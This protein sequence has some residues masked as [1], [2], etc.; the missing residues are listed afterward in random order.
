[1]V[2]K[3]YIINLIIL[4]S[5][6]VLGFFSLMGIHL[7]FENIQNKFDE[8]I[9]NEEIRYRIGERI[10]RHINAVETHY[11]KM[12]TLGEQIGIERIRKDILN[13]T[14]IIRQ[15]LDVLEKG[16]TAELKTELNLAESH[17]ETEMITYRKMSYERLTIE[18]IDLA[19]KLTA[20]EH[21]VDELAQFILQRQLHENS[22]QAEQEIIIFL[23]QLP[24]HFIR[25]KENA[26]RLLYESRK[27]MHLVEIQS[28]KE[29]A[30]Y[31][32]LQYLVAF[33]VIG[34]IVILGTLVARG[35][36]RTNKELVQSNQ[37]AKELA[38]KAQTADR[39]KSQFLA[40]MSHEIR[41]PLNG[42]IG[43]SHILT[44][45]AITAQNREYA[46]IIYENSHGLLDIIN[47]ILDISKI[48]Q[49]N[50]DI[51][52]EPFS[53]T[54]VLEKVVELFAIKAKE[55]S[56][57]F[58]FYASPTI[59]E[60]VIGDAVRLRQVLSN[61]LGNAI[62][63]T[64]QNGRVRFEVRQ[65]EID[66]HYVLLRFAIEDSGVGIPKQQQKKIFEPFVQADDGI[67]RKFGGTG[68]GLSISSD[69]IKKMGSS[70]GLESEVGVGSK[71]YFDMR[72][73]IGACFIPSEK[74]ES[75]HIFAILGQPTEFPEHLEV[76]QVYL[77]KWGKLQAWNPK[78]RVDALFCYIM[79]PDI[80]EKIVL[81]K[82]AFPHVLIIALRD[83][84]IGTLP[85]SLEPIV[86][87][88]LEC[89][90]YGSKIFNA[91]VS[92]FKDK[93]SE[94]IP[95]T[96]II[97]IGGKILVAE[98]N[99]TNRQLMQIYLEKLGVSFTMV[100]NGEE[101][102][103]LYCKENFDLVLMDINMPV[104]DGIAA[105]KA[106][107]ENEQT[108][109]RNHTPIIALTA[110]TLKGDKERYVTMGM[111]G[112]LS[113]PIVFEDLRN[114]L[115][116]YITTELMDKDEPLGLQTELK[117]NID[118]VA[119]A[120]KMGLDIV[121]LEMIL[122]NF[123]LTLEDDLAKLEN[124]CSTGNSE[125]IFK[126]AHYLKG[127]CANLFLDEAVSL[128][129]YIEKNHTEYEANMSSLRKYFKSYM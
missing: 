77:Y 114:L 18:L 86:D 41:T 6:F 4:M 39:A 103:M 102:L 87:Q 10:I 96:E 73:P 63:F 106:I 33:G 129:E 110:N 28:G 5:V 57:R 48:E 44:Q 65:L 92:L 91:I 13:E 31:D 118:K 125:E 94:T 52:Q 27:E 16:G 78:K 90:L 75:T 95:Q 51:V 122:D 55:K 23:K 37:N 24:T 38:I 85:F 29:K 119:I 1:M 121:T 53:P 64:P 34:L 104:M 59:P 66:M 113:K 11:Y 15:L 2:Q 68:L 107:L 111:D 17:V 128:L 74:R 54:D 115:E 100:E 56:I 127:A 69:I 76:L 22:H 71:F 123:F 30:F 120:T 25:M 89:P 32:L 3:N 124:A 109:A 97:A 98:D 82:K 19:P 21:K 62:K 36:L 80:E 81:Y 14:N 47:D 117:E 93:V 99:P 35:I 70:I 58:H 50:I 9:H 83:D 112:H 20:L 46:R 116:K 105:T 7:F 84:C 40:N 42:I 88:L 49:G 72:L 61:L 101:A 79:T 108:F 60:F 26:A 43:F 45:S 67:E 126:A 12:A 8:K